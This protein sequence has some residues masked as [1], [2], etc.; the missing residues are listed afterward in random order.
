MKNTL[1]GILAIFLAGC[2][3]PEQAGEVSTPADSA[4]PMASQD[5]SVAAQPAPAQGDVTDE[6]IGMPAYPGASEVEYTRVK[7][8]S[9]VGDTYSVSYRTSDSPTQVAAF[10]QAEAAKV[11]KLKQSMATSELLKSVSVDR[12][13]GSQSAIQAM[14]DGKGTTII[15][16]HRFFPSKKN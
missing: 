7:Q 10:Y 2:G 15:S 1:I 11:G 4:P 12:T 8:H 16:V 14:T 9:D 6:K 3:A 5:E 13:D